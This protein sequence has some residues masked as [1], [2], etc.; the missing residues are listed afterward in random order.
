MSG[1]RCIWVYALAAFVLC[2]ALPRDARADVR[3]VVFVVEQPTAFSARLR[4]E[5]ETMGFEIVPATA[6]DGAP[7][8]AVAAV[9]VIDA[10]EPRHV[11]LWTVNAGT[12]RL[13]LTGVVQPSP[14]DDETSQT[15]RASEQLRAF[16]QPLRE[17]TSTPETAPVAPAPVAPPPAPPVP[18]APPIAP[19][20][21]P[22][23]A[24]ETAP[25][26]RRLT[27]GASLAVPL[28]Q[29]GP[30]LDAFVQGRFRF[31]DAFAVG[32]VVALPFVH[33]KV[34]SGPNS[35][36]VSATLLDAEL[37]LNVVESRALRLTADAG[38][39]AVWIRTSGSARTPYTAKTDDAFVAM[40]LLGAE[41]AP[42][43]SEWIRVCL[44][45]R[46]G[47]A[48]P[49]PDVDFAGRSV[50]TLGRPLVLLSAGVT[51]DL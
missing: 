50:A 38:V 14:S 21:A 46:A 8:R 26:E 12:G 34:E 10:P 15:V 47:F 32:G 25:R 7:V 3:N 51:V 17:S 40:P 39:G 9:R 6:I 19:P 37:S 11:E 2:S 1:A 44:G 30:G 24:A 29:G 16:F 41:L 23:P 18:P 13:E 43:L 22:N 35:A 5:I 49:K 28:Q 4:A 36:D 48:L 33:S 31:T 20:R 27:A 45:A 42:A